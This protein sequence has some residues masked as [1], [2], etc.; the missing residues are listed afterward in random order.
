MKLVLVQQHGTTIA[1]S[2]CSSFE[3]LLS[4][5]LALDVCSARPRIHKVPDKKC[6]PAATLLRIIR[7]QTRAGHFTVI[8]S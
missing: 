1:A 7:E 3:E 8:P 6:R 4:H 5:N 2:V